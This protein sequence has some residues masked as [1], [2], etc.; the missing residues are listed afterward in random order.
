MF[1]SRIF[2]RSS[3][4]VILL[5]SS[6][7]ITLSQFGISI[8][9]AIELAVTPLSPVIITTRTPALV[10]RRISPF[11]D[12]RG[13][14]ARPTRPQSTSL[15]E[16]NSAGIFSLSPKSMRPT[17]ITRRP[18]CDISSNFS[19]VCLRISS[20]ESHSVRMRSGEPFAATVILSPCFQT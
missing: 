4:S 12:N 17:A 6:P 1:T 20:D 13:G 7:V 3:S 9:F 18:F 15:H 11:T 19:S 16:V 5:I 8:F 2:S 10:Q 14:S